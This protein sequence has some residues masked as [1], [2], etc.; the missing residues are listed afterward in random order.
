MGSRWRGGF[1]CVGFNLATG[2]FHIVILI[3]LSILLYEYIQYV[4][5]IEKL[6]MAPKSRSSCESCCVDDCWKNGSRYV[7]SLW[8]PR[9]F[10]LRTGQ[11]SLMQQCGGNLLYV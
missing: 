3:S 9:C 5:W 10:F 1:S 2:A 11:R 7:P 8:D 6:S 4:T